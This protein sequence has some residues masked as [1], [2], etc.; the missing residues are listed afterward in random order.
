[1]SNI[2]ALDSFRLAGK[3]VII[4]GG[5]GGLCGT[6]ARALG[7]IGMRVAVLDLREESAQA[8]ARA[9]S[10]AGGE[11]VA[12]GCSVLDEAQLVGVNARIEDRWGRVD[13]LINGAGGNDPKASTEVE[14]VDRADPAWK[15]GPNFLNLDMAGFERAIRLNFMGTVIPTK[16]FSRG[17][18]ERGTGSIV[19]IS[20][21]S[22]FVPLTKIPAYSAA[23]ASVANFTKWLA[24]HY[25][26]AGV[27]VNAIAPGFFIGNQNR[28]LLMDA[29]TGDLT[30]RG[31]K[32]IAHTPFGRF[33]NV[34]E[35][36]GALLFLASEAAA[37]FVT[38]VTLPVDG[39]Y[40]V[41][42]V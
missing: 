18:V 16:V 35:L 23:K 28:A 24:V 27:R 19:N 29:A 14:F 15:D 17:M 10:G 8:T 6:L 31:R 40:L 25:A 13:C 2:S 34:T 30:E 42:N 4:T 11:A 39:G 36:A 33:G 32:I 38:G 37:G 26:Q 22:A 12:F 9:V 21:M 7:G 1:M 20:S 3:S 5:G 41:D